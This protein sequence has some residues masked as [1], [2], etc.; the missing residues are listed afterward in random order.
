M[1]VT[2]LTISKESESNELI[3]REALPCEVVR[4]HFLDYK[5]NKPFDAIVNLGVTEHLPDYAASLAQY[6]KLLKPG[7]RV[8]L[9]A[10]ASRNKFPFS[11]FILK[12]IWPGN[13]TPLHLPSYLEV[14]SET[15]LELSNIQNDRQSYLLTTRCWAEN[16]DRQSSFVTDRWARRFTAAFA[17]I[18]GIVCNAL[19]QTRSPRTGGCCRCR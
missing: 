3:R 8:Y 2:S 14:L 10:C 12:Y 18:S 16:F 11:A 9:D 5:N 19:P 6:Q 1:Q 7:G 4:E 13:A 17:S 15:L